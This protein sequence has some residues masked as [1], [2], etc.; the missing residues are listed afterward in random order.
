M[1]EPPQY[2][3]GSDLH[4]PYG[5]V[6]ELPAN[7]GT[8]VTAAVLA[9]VGSAVHLL[10]VLALFSRIDVV[11]RSA[12]ALT[13]LVANVVLVALLLPGAVLLLLRRVVGQ[14]FVAI[15]AGVAIGY[16]AF[17]V[18]AGFAAS[19]SLNG[20]LDSDAADYLAGA[21][22]LQAFVICLPAI[23]TLVLALIAPTRRWVRQQRAW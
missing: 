3:Q 6:P 11:V 2:P 15:G 18:L 13:S 23:A 22:G 5:V 8:A 17:M 19:L 7:R 16:F 10:G 20:E 12:F 9:L 1:S 14:V 4:Q 21:G